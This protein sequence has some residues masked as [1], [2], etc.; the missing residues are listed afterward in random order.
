MGI[1]GIMTTPKVLVCEVINKK[2]KKKFF[3]L[4]TIQSANLLN[5][6]LVNISDDGQV[7]L[8]PKAEFGSTCKIICKAPFLLFFS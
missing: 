5:T 3:C 7:S 6:V 8:V 4:V 1:I 2:K